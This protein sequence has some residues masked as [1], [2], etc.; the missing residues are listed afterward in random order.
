MKN[1]L[2]KRQGWISLLLCVLIVAAFLHGWFIS[3][4]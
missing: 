1:F 2:Q 3:W 4:E